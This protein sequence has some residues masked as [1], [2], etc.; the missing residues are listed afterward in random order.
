MQRERPTKAFVL[1]AGFGTRML[2]LSRDLPKPLMPLWGVPI[3]DRILDLLKRWGVKEVVINL[4]HNPDE[5][6]ALGRSLARPDFK[7]NFS[8]EPEILGSCVALN[9]SSTTTPSGSSTPILSPT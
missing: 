1:A 7:I 3:L 5:I 8:F 4:H 2:P 9:G 6:F